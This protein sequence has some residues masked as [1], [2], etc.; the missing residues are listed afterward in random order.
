MVQD[1]LERRLLER[2]L[3]GCGLLERHLVDGRVL[4]RRSWSDVS[5]EDN[6]D[7]EAILDGDGYELTPA[8][9]EAAA[10]DVDLLTP[11]E[12]AA[13][14]ALKRQQRSRLRPKRRRL[15]RQRAG[16]AA[17]ADGG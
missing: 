8:E 16:R 1:L 14:G 5:S 4:E 7:G 9:A 13:L 17:E 12:K 10:E 2:R 3:V 15:K 6:A 11:E